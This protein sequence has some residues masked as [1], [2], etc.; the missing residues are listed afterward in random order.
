MDSTGIYARQGFA[1]PLGFG[2]APALV[3]VDF[4]AGFRDPALFG[5]GNVEEAIPAAR[6]LLQAA[7]ELRLPV[8]HTRIAHAPGKENDNLWARKAP[9]LREL[10]DGHPAAE[11]VPELAPL[12][13][14]LVVTK[15]QA[16]A[17]FATPLRGWLAERRAD[18]VVLA[19]CTTS[20]CVRA[21]AVDA[22]SHGLFTIVAG[23]ACSDRAPDSHATALFELA[24]KYADVLAADAILVRLRDLAV[25][26]T[27]A[28]A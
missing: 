10:V 21:S 3:L 19:G 25:K 5:G 26:A 17:F 9:R 27:E 24:Q 11:F 1:H 15:T 12:P 4:T 13:G 18:T 7:R 16:S 14:E 28:Q 22:I 2:N 20:G 23:D 8:A 6:R